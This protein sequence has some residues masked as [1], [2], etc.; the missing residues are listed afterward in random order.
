[1]PQL[2]PE[3]FRDALDTMSRYWHHSKGMPKAQKEI[4]RWIRQHTGTV[5]AMKQPLRV[6]LG[7]FYLFYLKKPAVMSEPNSIRLA[8]GDY[9][10]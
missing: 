3:F 10:D 9:F 8:D 1:M 6:R 5:L 2:G 4:R 7:Y